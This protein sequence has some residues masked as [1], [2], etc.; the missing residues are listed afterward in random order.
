MRWEGLWNRFL[1]CIEWNKI[2]GRNWCSKNDITKMK[3]RKRGTNRKW[4]APTCH[5][6]L[7]IELKRS[8]SVRLN[9]IHSVTNWCITS[10]DSSLPLWKKEEKFWRTDRQ[11]SSRY[12][13]AAHILVHLLNAYARMDAT[14]ACIQ[15]SLKRGQH[16]ILHKYSSLYML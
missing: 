15:I 13:S 4:D 10:C 11:S 3:E 9:C 8:L 1:F 7:G 6:R 14:S 12:E 2:V 16:R 5:I